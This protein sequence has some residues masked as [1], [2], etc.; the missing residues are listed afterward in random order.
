MILQRF[1]SRAIHYLLISLRIWLAKHRYTKHKYDITDLGFLGI[2][3]LDLCILLYMISEISISYKE[4]VRLYD[5]SLWIFTW[6][7]FCLE[8]FGTNDYALRGLFVVLHCC[9]MFF[10]YAIG[11]IYLKKPND[12]LLLVLIYALLPGI[13]ISALMIY[14][15]EFILCV[16]LFIC[17]IQLRFKTMP[18]IVIFA[19]GW[20]DLVFCVL[21][22]AL[23][24]YA[25]IHRKTTIFVA[26]LI[27]FG[28]NMFLYSSSIG[29]IPQA[30]FFDVLGGFAMLFSPLLFLY[31]VYTLYAAIA[32]RKEDSLMVLISVSGVVLSLLLSL[33]QEI[34]LVKFAPLCVVGLPVLVYGFFNDMR[35]RLKAYRMRFK[36]RMFLVFSVLCLETFC[37][38]GNKLSYFFSSNPNFAYPYYIAKDVANELKKRGIDSIK[39]Q[40][41]SLDLR[42]K[43][44]GISVGSANCL[45]SDTN[46]KGELIQIK[47]LGRVVAQYTLVRDNACRI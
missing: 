15:S 37:L 44:Y 1:S 22:V 33:R 12:S 14:E 8:V 6:V 11:R 35:V 38:Y 9:N 4:T 36:V 18:Y 10:M 41:A 16:L 46:H 20:F 13:N 30:Y 31:Y 32:R 21:F 25:L 2:L 45:Y 7:R 40:D 23:G 5:S 26:A 17:Y 47:Y 43:F 24:I 28:I 34:N 42:L 19:I 3:L 29:G 39:V 27:G